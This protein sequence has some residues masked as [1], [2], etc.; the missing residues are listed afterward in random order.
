MRVSRFSAA[1]VVACAIVGHLR[2]GEYASERGFSL[3]YPD[4]WKVTSKE[5]L[6][7]VGRLAKPYLEKAEVSSSG[8]VVIISKPGN[9]RFA[10]NLNVV[11]SSA[12]FEV[13]EQAVKE[14]VRETRSAYAKAG[15]KVSNVSSQI[16]E[17]AG[18]KAISLKQD[19]LFP[20]A[21]E[22]VRQ[23]Q[24]IIPGKKH[25]YTVTCSAPV[26]DF[27]VVEPVF[28]KMLQSVKVDVGDRTGRPVQRALEPLSSVRM[29]TASSTGIT[30]IFPSPTWP[31][32]A[33]L[34][35]AATTP[36]T[37]LSLTTTSILILG[38]KSTVY[39]LP[40]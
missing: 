22:A 17:Y 1:L 5:H 8:P 14:F 16:A 40:R 36:A 21:T 38:T 28:A 29:R 37:S 20:N 3:T 23:W 12:T 13:T 32:F 10:E 26:S 4:D 39:S 19:S 7:K 25:L 24:L 30:K 9:Q 18:R 31:V 15:I 2:A 33:A 6:E 27:A 35:M 11:V 34:E